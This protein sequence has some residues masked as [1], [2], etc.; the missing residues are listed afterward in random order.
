MAA[1]ARKGRKRL[2]RALAERLS[3]AGDAPV[4]AVF[5]LR[6][7]RK[8]RALAPSETRKIVAKIVKRAE[9]KA[10]HKAHQLNILANIQ[11]F[12]LRGHAPLIHEIANAPEVEAAEL[13]QALGPEALIR[14]VDQKSVAPEDLHKYVK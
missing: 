9:S 2:D 4:E 8:G 10:A 7:S 12:A 1:A 11:R 3:Q 13:N 14:P 5:T 6:S